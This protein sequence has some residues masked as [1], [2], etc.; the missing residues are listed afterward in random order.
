M[1][2]TWVLHV[3]LRS[4]SA[5]KQGIEIDPQAFL[6]VRGR[7]LCWGWDWEGV[8]RSLH[9][10]VSR[11]CAGSTQ[12]GCSTPLTLRTTSG[13]YSEALQRTRVCHIKDEPNPANGPTQGEV[14]YNNIL[15]DEARR[16]KRVHSGSPSPWLS[17]SPSRADGSWP[18]GAGP[19]P[20]WLGKKTPGPSMRT[21][22]PA[23][24]LPRWGWRRGARRDKG[25]HF[26]ADSH[27]TRRVRTFHLFP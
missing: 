6:L 22:L 23:R 5:K 25:A 12:R 16:T 24:K 17:P 10:A 1:K 9:H 8:L 26:L 20:P 4:T 14:K 13:T 7:H 2:C 27:G 18:A 11:A 19:A 3:A 15:R 21:P